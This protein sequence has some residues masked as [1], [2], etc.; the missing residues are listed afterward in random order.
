MDFDKKMPVYPM[1]V[2]ARMLDVH[3]RTLRIYE[4]EGLIQ[5]QRQ[6]GKRFFSQNDIIWIKCL[7]QLIHD[8]NISI[9]GIKKLLELLPCWKLKD[10]PPE[11]KAKCSALK[12]REK[13]CWELTKNA[14]E[15]SCKRCEIYLKRKPKGG[16]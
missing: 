1:C 15:K 6:G 4:S 5:P 8:Q 14:C 7:R 3:P 12:E 11:I 13:R 9:P 2:A 16:L 10:C